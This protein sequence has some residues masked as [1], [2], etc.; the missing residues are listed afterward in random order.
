MFLFL[1]PVRY[2]CK[3]GLSSVHSQSHDVTWKDWIRLKTHLQE[4]PIRPTTALLAFL[5]KTTPSNSLSGEN[6]HIPAHHLQRLL[7]DP[8]LLILEVFVQKPRDE[9]RWKG[10]YVLCYY[11]LKCVVVRGVG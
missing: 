9:L 11:A 3:R 4:I 5:A 8:R 10:R 2:L 1:F 6:I 7:C